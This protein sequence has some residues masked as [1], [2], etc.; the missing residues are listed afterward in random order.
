[1]SQPA[2]FFFFHFWI[3]FFAASKVVFFFDKKSKQKNVF[4]EKFGVTTKIL[5]PKKGRFLRS[6]ISKKKQESQ[7]KKKVGWEQ[8]HQLNDEAFGFLKRVIITCTPTVYP[9]F[10]EFHQFD[11]QI[12][13]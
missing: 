13:G 2:F 3:F 12:T 4:S 5:I 9:R 7:L 11:I 8:L 6:F 1:M 10:L